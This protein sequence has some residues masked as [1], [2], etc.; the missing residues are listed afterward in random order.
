MT[1]YI[2]SKFGGDWDPY[3]AKWASDEAHMLKIAGRGGAAGLKK[4]G[5]KMNCAVLATYAEKVSQ[6]VLVLH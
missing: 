5:I 2:D 6:R 4:K 3:I 1:A